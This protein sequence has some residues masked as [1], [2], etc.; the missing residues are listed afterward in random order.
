M[1]LNRK[2]YDNNLSFGFRRSG[3]IRYWYRSI[4]TQNCLRTGCGLPA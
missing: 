4:E 2:D 3:T 1:R